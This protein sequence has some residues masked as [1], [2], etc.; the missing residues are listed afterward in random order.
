MRYASKYVT[1]GLVLVIS[2]AAWAGGSDYGFKPGARPNLEGK[3]SEWDVPTPKFARDPTPG[4]AGQVYI[5][6][7]HGNKIARFDPGAK[8]FKEWDLPEGASPH[9]LLVD[10]NGQV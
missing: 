5:A 3:I 9:G 8:A 10:S 1:V 6:A 7:M 2:G 4:P